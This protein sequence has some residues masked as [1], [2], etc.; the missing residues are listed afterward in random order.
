MYNVSTYVV[1]E[2]MHKKRF[3]I[4]NGGELVIIRREL[5]HGLVHVE[6]VFRV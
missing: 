6:S 1:K 2:R 5:K 3:T 4:C